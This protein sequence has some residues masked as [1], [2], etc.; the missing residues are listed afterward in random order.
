MMSAGFVVPALMGM[1]AWATIKNM[2]KEFIDSID[3]AVQQAQ[4][5]PPPPPGMPGD[6]TMGDP[7]LLPPQVG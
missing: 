4:M 5:P 7:S 2:P 6:P 3:M 1:K